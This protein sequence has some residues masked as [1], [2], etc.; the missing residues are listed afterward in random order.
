MSYD[1]IQ[2]QQDLD[3]I[4]QSQP[5]HMYYSFEVCGFVAFRI[6]TEWA[7]NLFEFALAPCN[8]PYQRFERWK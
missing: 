3:Q 4:A 7:N 8:Q 5:T 1:V 6:L 2:V